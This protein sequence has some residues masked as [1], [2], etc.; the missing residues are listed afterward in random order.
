MLM[1]LDYLVASNVIQ[2]EVR[3]TP[4]FAYPADVVRLY[5]NDALSCTYT[6]TVSNRYNL[7]DDTANDDVP[8]DDEVVS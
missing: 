7:G 8:P 5:Q 4:R 1:F 2:K 3:G 6:E